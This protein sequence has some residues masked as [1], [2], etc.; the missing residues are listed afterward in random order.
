M[1]VLVETDVAPLN[2]LSG[3]LVLKLTFF[4][5]NWKINVKALALTYERV[6]LHGARC[7]PWAILNS[8]RSIRKK[9]RQLCY[10]WY[11]RAFAYGNNR[12]FFCVS[13]IWKLSPSRITVLYCKRMSCFNLL[14]YHK[15]KD[16]SNIK[17]SFSQVFCIQWLIISLDFHGQ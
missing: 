1:K 10:R 16:G 2:F 4:S 7:A 8:I 12:A 9:R 11:L 17:D 15:Y 14:S 3:L 13:A 6:L 5:V